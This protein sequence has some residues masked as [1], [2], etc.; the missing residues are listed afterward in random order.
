VFVIINSVIFLI[1]DGID[2][3]FYTEKYK[4]SSNYSTATIFVYILDM[5]L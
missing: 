3:T 4:Y 2:A 5:F 1:W